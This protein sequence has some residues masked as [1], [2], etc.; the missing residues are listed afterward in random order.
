VQQPAPQPKQPAPEPEIELVPDVEYGSPLL[1]IHD[2][3]MVQAEPDILARIVKNDP[4]SLLTVVCASAK[5]ALTEYASAHT[6]CGKKKPRYDDK[7]DTSK[8]GEYWPK[9]AQATDY[10]HFSKLTKGQ[11]TSVG[12]CVAMRFLREVGAVGGQEDLVKTNLVRETDLAIVFSVSDYVQIFKCTQK[13]FPKL[14]YRELVEKIATGLC[15]DNAGD[16]YDALV[17]HFV[18][19]YKS[20]AAVESNTKKQAP[21][22]Q[23]TEAGNGSVVNVNG[24]A[25]VINITSE[26]LSANPEVLST[27][28]S[29]VSVTNTEKTAAAARKSKSHC[30]HFLV[31]FWNNS[32]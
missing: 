3:K 14:N 19:K 24:N 6:V 13:K 23:M 4:G 12:D 1:V 15:S 30:A 29:S 11:Q 5:A 32:N 20:K 8:P 22:E 31:W 25:T 26:A 21:E 9:V 27:V 7:R 2:T 16:I 18:E 17:V 28:L 10:E